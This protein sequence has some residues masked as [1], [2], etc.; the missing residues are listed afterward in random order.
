MSS[1]E[2]FNASEVSAIGGALQSDAK[3]YENKVNQGHFFV[4]FFNI[5]YVILINKKKEHFTS[6]PLF[7]YFLLLSY[8]LD[9]NHFR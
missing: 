2:S 4:G 3:N 9:Q 8:N 1:L 6:V 7:E 5:E